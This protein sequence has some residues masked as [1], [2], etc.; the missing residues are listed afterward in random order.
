MLLFIVYYCTMLQEEI[1][2]NA[3]EELLGVEEEDEATFDRKTEP[4]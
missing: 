2:N 3:M 4:Q 1:I